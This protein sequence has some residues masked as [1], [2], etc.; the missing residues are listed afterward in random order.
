MLESQFQRD[1]QQSLKAA[2]AVTFHVHGGDTR[3]ASGWP[4]LYVAHRKWNG[5]LELKVG[6]QLSILQ[7]QRITDLR[8]RGVYAYVLMWNVGF[9]IVQNVERE[10]LAAVEV[11]KQ[12][13]GHQLLNTLWTLR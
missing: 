3:Q 11:T 10:M 1:V 9:W 6:A 4:D 5:W 13:V 2:G 7:K 12:D 8:I